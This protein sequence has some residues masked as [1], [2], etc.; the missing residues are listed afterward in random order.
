M[1]KVIPFRKIKKDTPT[2]TETMTVELG[3]ERIHAILDDDSLTAAERH[4]ILE[5][6]LLQ[7]EEQ[8]EQHQKELEKAERKLHDLVQA[9]EQNIASASLEHHSRKLRRFLPWREA[10][11]S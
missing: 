9:A 5:N 7:I 11:F 4:W 8:L 3:F 1:G 2:R 10:A 6:M